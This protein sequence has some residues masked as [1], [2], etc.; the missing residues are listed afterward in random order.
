MVSAIFYMLYCGLTN[1][2]NGLLWISLSLLLVECAVLIFNKGVCPLTPLASKYTLERQD[3]FDIYLPNIIAK[4]NKQ[5]F[6][7]LFIMALT[8]IIYNLFR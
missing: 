1:T 5:I 4:Y 6:G 3:N 8:L 2:F 7:I